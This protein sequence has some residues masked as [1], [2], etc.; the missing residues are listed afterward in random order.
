MTRSGKGRQKRVDLRPNSQVITY[1]S[2]I[3]A[4]DYVYPCIKH[5]EAAYVGLYVL[6]C[7]SFWAYIQLSYSSFFV[8]A[9]SE[10]KKHEGSKFY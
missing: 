6:V 9:Q 4:C 8:N 3:F 7:I 5:S 1:I 10:N 2:P